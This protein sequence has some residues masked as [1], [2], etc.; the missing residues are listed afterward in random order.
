MR[1]SAKVLIGVLS[2]A[3]LIGSGFAV[4]TVNYGSVTKVEKLINPAFDSE[5]EIVGGNIA[6]EDA[7]AN[8]SFTQE[9]QNLTKQYI[10]KS[11]DTSWYGREFSVGTKA[12][13]KVSLTV[14]AK[15]EAY[16]QYITLPAN[17]EIGYEDW[18]A[19]NKKESGYAI[20]LAFGYV[21]SGQQNPKDYFAEHSTPAAEQETYYTGLV[22]ALKDIN[23]FKF[24]FELIEMDR[25]V[26]SVALDQHELELEFDADPV[27]LHATVLP[28]NASNKA[29]TWASSNPDVASVNE[30]GVVTP[31]A[32]G[33]ATITV[34]SV[35]GEKTDTCSV[36]VTK[37]MAY[38]SRSVAGEGEVSTLMKYSLGSTYDAENSLEFAET[39]RGEIVGKE[40]TVHVE[41]TAAE[42]YEYKGYK[43]AYSE[44]GVDYVETSLM[45]ADYTFTVANGYYHRITP[46][47][48]AVVIVPPT[49]ELSGDDAEKVDVYYTLK[50]DGTHYQFAQEMQDLIDKVITIHVEA[51]DGYGLLGFDIYVKEHDDVSY[52]SALDTV[53]EA[54]F[55]YETT[56]FEGWDYRIEPVVEETGDEPEP[57]VLT[58]TYTF[59]TGNNTGNDDQLT[60]NDYTIGASET[61][62]VSSWT[63]TKGYANSSDGWKFGSS[64]AKGILS[65]V[66]NSAYNV[67]SVSVMMKKHGSDDTVVIMNGTSFTLTADFAPYE[68]NITD[69]TLSIAA[70]KASKQRYYISSITFTYTAA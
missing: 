64:S 62:I 46:V 11:L 34:T 8:L 70:A 35:D 38:F 47:Y 4:W 54:P 9:N 33:Q 13:L 31:Q 29:V 60:S 67:S 24:T 65:I 16:L 3:A 2:A 1:K 5:I 68:A 26:S 66:C 51:H 50:D 59:N 49:F 15:S 58:T 36:H 52:G 14:D 53:E 6:V 20:N 23:S 7:N 43:L 21:L 32:E 25:S 41:G 55:V 42:G 61:D 17:Q 57:Q 40:I 30:N 69:N 48:E 19:A 27:T 44:D 18:L 22:A 12:D 37:T 28:N 63:S 10:A 56:I 45:T 39:M